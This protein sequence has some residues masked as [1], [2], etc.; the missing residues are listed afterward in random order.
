MNRSYLIGIMVCKRSRRKR[1]LDLYGDHND[2]KLKLCSF[3]PAD[4]RWRKKAV[5]VVCKQKG[6]WKRKKLR[7]PKVVY[8]RCYELK[9]S[10]ILR[11]ERLIGKNRCF[12]RINQLNKWGIYDILLNTNLSDHLPKTYPYSE[13]ESLK[14]KSL[15]F[16]KPCLGFQGRGIF[17]IER[18]AEGHINISQNTI[19]P[20]YI[21][22]EPNNLK[23]ELDQLTSKQ[24]KYILQE[25]IPFVQINNRFFDIRVLVQKDNQGEWGVSTIISR[26]AYEGYYN[27]SITESLCKVDEVLQQLFSPSEIDQILESLNF[28]STEAAKAIDNKLKSMGELSVDFGIDTDG[29]LWIIEV[30]GNPQRSIY[31]D[32]PDL[33]NSNLVYKRPLE[34]ARYLARRKS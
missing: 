29:K 3:T 22:R 1:V 15:L 19:P 12:N 4:I 7:L 20:R 10:T 26:M 31:K 24:S 13:L 34:Y 8:N 33:K 27:T 2:L 11:L 28:I 9:G 25:G 14:N 30:N 5:T 21:C 32:V 23:Q 16:L 6:K 17:R 18:M